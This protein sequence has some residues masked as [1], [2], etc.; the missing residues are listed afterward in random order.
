MANRGR[1]LYIC[2]VNWI[3]LWGLW[4]MSMGGWNY[5]P[6]PKP[7]L[8]MALTS[9]HKFYMPMEPF[10][11]PIEAIIK[12]SSLRSITKGINNRRRGLD[13]ELVIGLDILLCHAM[14]SWSMLLL[15]LIMQSK[16]MNFRK[17]LLSWSPV[18]KFQL[19]ASLPLWI[20]FIKIQHEYPYFINLI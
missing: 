3:P 10:M 13:S 11:W 7:H 18:S 15:N 19:Q 17:I 9:H 14:G 12:L 20:D 2:H 1:K 16:P 5:F 8:T 4:V 6:L